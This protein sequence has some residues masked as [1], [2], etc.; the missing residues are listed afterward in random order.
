MWGELQARVARRLFAELAARRFRWAV[1]GERDASLN[2]AP[3]RC[4]HV[5]D[6]ASFEATV[7]GLSACVRTGGILVLRHA[8][9]RFGDCA[10]S[11]DYEPVLVG[12]PSANESTVTPLYD[13]SNTLADPGSRDDGLYR[14]VE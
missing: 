8:N 2:D 1:I 3:P 9:F 12:L 5:L 10:V 6:F 4:D 13:R 7:A 11:A 14:K